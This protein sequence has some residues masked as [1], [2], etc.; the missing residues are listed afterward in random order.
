MIMSDSLKK[1][2][3]AKSSVLLE[4]KLLFVRLF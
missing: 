2:K 1:D 3:E 4:W